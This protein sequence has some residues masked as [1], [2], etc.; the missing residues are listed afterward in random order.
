MRACVCVDSGGGGLFSPFTSPGWDYFSRA[1]VLTDRTIGKIA[2]CLISPFRSRHSVCHFNT[3]D[4]SCINLHKT[5]VY[6][7]SALRVCVCVSFIFFSIET[8]VSL[9]LKNKS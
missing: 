2:E 3:G 7:S 1:S 5:K 6:K 9:L 4:K 8:E